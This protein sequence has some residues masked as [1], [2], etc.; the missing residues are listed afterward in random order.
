MSA[1]VA[2]GLYYN[3]Q[4]GVAGVLQMCMGY[5]TNLAGGVSTITANASGQRHPYGAVR[6]GLLAAAR[7]RH[8]DGVMATGQQNQI[9]VSWQLMPRVGSR[10]ASNIL[11]STTANR[12]LYARLAA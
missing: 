9:L 10:P 11:R 3:F 4:P 7:H 12:P 8:A 1:A 2:D 5:T 6:H